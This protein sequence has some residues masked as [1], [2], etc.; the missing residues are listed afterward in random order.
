MK[1]YYISLLVIFILCSLNIYLYI[2]FKS[3]KN[4]TA[5]Y[6]KATE[7]NNE[8]TIILQTNIEASIQ[9]AGYSIK[10]TVLKDSCNQ[11]QLLSHIQIKNKYLFICFFSELDCESCVNYSIQT[12]L[13]WCED[14]GYENILFIGQYRNNKLFY[15]QLPLYNLKSASVYNSYGLNLPLKDLGYPFYLILDESYKIVEV[16]IPSKGNYNTDQYFLQLLNT[17]FFPNK[18]KDEM[19]IG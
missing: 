3:F 2:H 12:L 17:H 1:K 9:N 10:N 15:Q 16:Y 18:N 11:K 19:I 8:R 4:K 5:T 7:Y 13:P 6:L 14:I